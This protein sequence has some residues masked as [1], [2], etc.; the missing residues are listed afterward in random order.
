ME[1]L[2]KTTA[3]KPSRPE[4]IIQFG[5]GN[6][7]RGFVDWIILEMN[8]K[9]DFNSSVVILPGRAGS[10]SIEKHI[11]QDYL[12]HLNLQGK[13]N[14]KTVD[15]ITLINTVSRGINPDNDFEGFL[16]LADI[17]EMRFV[18]SNTTEAGIIF[19][20]QCKFND[21]PASSF[22][23]RL[24]QL[25]Y[26][27]FKTFEGNEEKGFIILP[28]ELIFD[29]GK[30]LKECIDSYIDLWKN[31]LKDDYL[32]LKK[33]VNESCYF[34]STLVDR[35]VT[36]SPKS[37]LK[38]L[39]ERIGLEDNLIVQGEVFHLWVIE[40]PEN[41]TVEQLKK[42]F[43]AEKADLNVLI[44]ESESAYHEMKVRLLNAPHTLL[45]PVAFLA[46]INIVRDAC[47]HTEISKYIRRVQIEELLPTIDLPEDA[48]KKYADDVMERFNNPYIDHQLESI[49]LNAFPK[50]AARVL[51]AL[52]FYQ[53]VNNELPAGMVFGL[54]ALINYYKGGKR[55]DGKEIIPND[56]PEII[57]FVKNLWK[58]EDYHK[59]AEGILSSELLWGKGNDL[60]L[61]P[62]LTSQLTIF[63]EDID[64]KGILESL[65]SL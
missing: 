33:W 53:K 63:L 39:Q 61:I 15:S 43:P 29:N 11:P 8:E 6:F 38:K 9:T 13:S 56:N 32:P 44:T 20:N 24:T 27:R 59:I 46:G 48:L 16:Q 54:A 34:C 26:R 35:I 22:P 51:P 30:K 2:N 45:S 18:I 25:L 64:K 60:T 42:E 65:Q 5:E 10:K 21:R 12:Y 7:L 50:Y 47:T 23:A 58:T 28:C 37:D 55:E 36:G 41:M 52:L 3:N 62:G 31:E 40:S 49:M 4:R 14:G 1:L 19:D 17:P 57:S